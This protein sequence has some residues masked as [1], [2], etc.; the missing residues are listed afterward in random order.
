MVGDKKVELS[1]SECNKIITTLEDGNQPII[2]R[3]NWDC[4]NK[5]KDMNP[6]DFF[7]ELGLGDDE[8]NEAQKVG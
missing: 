2:E 6:K 5:T 7:R 3:Y 4:F 1:W 8:L